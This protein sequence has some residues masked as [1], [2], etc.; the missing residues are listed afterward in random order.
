MPGE[1]HVLDLEADAASGGDEVLGLVPPEVT[2]TAVVAAV[3]R[4]EDRPGVP[5]SMRHRH[6]GPPSRG[7]DPGQLAQR[8]GVS[9]REAAHEIAVRDHERAEFVRRLFHRSVDDPLAYDAVVNDSFSSPAAITE[10]LAAAARQ[11]F[12]RLR[13]LEAPTG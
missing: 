8:R 1:L 12:E 4:T 11:K 10:W 5:Q 7:E 9:L 3:R 2:E 6:P 13:P